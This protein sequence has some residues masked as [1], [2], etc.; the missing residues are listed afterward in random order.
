MP[1]SRVVFVTCHLPYPSWSGG[2]LREHE[3]IR[4]LSATYE[5]DLIAVSKT[6][7][8]DAANAS[9]LEDLCARVSVFPAEPHL[10]GETEVPFQVLRHRSL[11][12]SRRVAEAAAE[13]DLIHVEG[14]YLMEHVPPTSPVPVLLVEQNI[15]YVLWRQRTESGPVEERERNLKEYLKTLEYEI[16]TWKHSSLCAAVTEDDRRIMLAAAAGLEVR[17]VPDGADHLARNSAGRPAHRISVAYI[18]NFAYQPNLDAALYLAREIW[19]RIH[20]R[21]PDAVL[22]LVGNEPPPEVQALARRDIVVTGRVE[23]VEPYLHSADVIVCP[24][25]IGGGVKVKVLE[26]L[27]AGKA[28]VTTGVGLQGLAHASNACIVEDEPGP[29][30]RAVVRHL[31][32]PRARAAVEQR[33]RAFARTLPTWDEAAAALDSCYRDLLRNDVVGLRS[34]ERKPRPRRA[35]TAKKARPLGTVSP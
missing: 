3:L 4:R 29:F 34:E 35:T 13:A 8:E 19:P 30:A 24:L 12:A 16:E 18:A 22:G 2:R 32:H 26:A 21:V 9:K 25:R 7:E 33:A 10:P 23:R 15:E 31:K 1:R 5:I 11:A 14:F 27:S 6:Y 20:A 28:L 17:V